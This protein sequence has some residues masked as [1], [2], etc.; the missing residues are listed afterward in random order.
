MLEQDPEAV[1]VIGVSRLG[2]N[3]HWSCVEERGRYLAMAFPLDQSYACRQDLPT[4]YEVNGT[5]YLWRR[6]YLL[7]APIDPCAS[8][9]PHRGLVIP[10][11]RGLDIDTDLD[12]RFVEFLVREGVVSLPWLK[13]TCSRSPDA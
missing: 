1:G 5:L 2:S 10:E 4:V 8:G 11:E 12:F 9:A 7:S 6:D 3:P 13:E